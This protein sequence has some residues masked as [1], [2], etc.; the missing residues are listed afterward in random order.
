M[1]GRSPFKR[2]GLSPQYGPSAGACVVVILPN[3]NLLCCNFPSGVGAGGV[4]FHCL[5]LLIGICYNSKFSLICKLHHGSDCS[6]VAN[7]NLG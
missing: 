5:S 6:F 4:S 7:K 1:S 2:S 3:G